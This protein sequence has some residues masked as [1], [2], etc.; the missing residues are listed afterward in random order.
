MVC[1][2]MQQDRGWGHATIILRT[3]LWGYACYYCCMP[4]PPVLVHIIYSALIPYLYCT[5]FSTFWH[6]HPYILQNFNGDI[7]LSCIFVYQN[8]ITFTDMHQTCVLLYSSRWIVV[9]MP[10]GSGKST[11][12][13]GSC[14]IDGTAVG[15][16][17]ISGLGLGAFQ[18]SAWSTSK[19]LEKVQLKRH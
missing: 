9:A 11:L 10:T 14:R 12:F 8:A 7:L 18:V 16:A 5:C 15:V 3:I 6:C 4:S 19:C 17:N 2:Y 1:T 13:K